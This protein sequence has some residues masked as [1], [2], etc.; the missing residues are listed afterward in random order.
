MG[1][2]IQA[3][4]IAS[5]WSAGMRLHDGQVQGGRGA[6]LRGL[7][8]TTVERVE[9]SAEELLQQLI[10]KLGAQKPPPP[11][12]LPIQYDAWDVEHIAKYMKLAPDTVRRKIVTDPKF[13]A[14]MR[15]T[16]DGPARWPARKV[17]AWLEA[18]A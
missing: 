5:A 13:P 10:E 18:R 12:P 3:A 6:G 11:P 9:M 16:S 2:D 14:A 7:D 17:V 4:L 15:P 1:S 8:E